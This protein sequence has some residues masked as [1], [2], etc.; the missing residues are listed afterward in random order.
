MTAADKYR[1]YMLGWRHGATGR[2]FMMERDNPHPLT[3]TYHEAYLDGVTAAERAS[4][5]ATKLTGYVP[6]ILREEK[7]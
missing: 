4:H 2:A 5:E 1:T 3:A 6:S 7:P